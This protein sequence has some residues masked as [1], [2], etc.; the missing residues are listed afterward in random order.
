MCSD[1]LN[2]TKLVGGS[3]RRASDNA[4]LVK[5]SEGRMDFCGSVE[6]STNFPKLQSLLNILGTRMVT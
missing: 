3:R 5:Y 1:N 4:E 2:K 6:G